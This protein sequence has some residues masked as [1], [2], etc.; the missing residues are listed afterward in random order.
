MLLYKTAEMYK[1]DSEMNIFIKV[2]FNAFN[3]KPNWSTLTYLNYY[4]RYVLV[5]SYLFCTSSN[6]DFLDVKQ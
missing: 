5:E 6:G 1:A 4:Y 3:S 2:Y